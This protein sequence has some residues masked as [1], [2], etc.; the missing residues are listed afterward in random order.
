VR[1][2]LDTN[3]LASAVATRGLCADL[4]REVLLSH[5]L[6]VSAAVLAELGRVLSTKFG[7]P[8]EVVAA[9]LGLGAIGEVRIL[10]PRQFWQ[11]LTGGTQ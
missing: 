1:L 7:A 11:S 5:T 4:V 8:P 3:V 9:V 2:F 10:S 6:V